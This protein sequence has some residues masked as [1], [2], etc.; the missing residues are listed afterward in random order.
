MKKIL[1]LI[2]F[3]CV[4][5]LAEGKIYKWTDENGSIHYSENKPENKISSEIKVKTSKG[6]PANS[7]ELENNYNL[8]KA[9]TDKLQRYAQQD[10][11]RRNK[12]KEQKSKCRLAKKS[13]QSL[14]DSFSIRKSNR[15]GSYIF[16]S[17]Q[18]EIK[19]KSRQQELIR[20]K[21]VKVDSA[22]KRWRTK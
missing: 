11:Y 16:P 10:Q 18:N 14:K 17:V 3:L 21:Q 5:C 22:C 4:Y 8:K 9:T 1:L 13:L 6:T 20:R 12:E 7:N 15:T 2:T 19:I